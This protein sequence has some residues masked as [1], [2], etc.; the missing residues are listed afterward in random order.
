MFDKFSKD[1]IKVIMQAQEE[2]RML[3]Q[4]EV[5]CKHL[6][7][8]VFASEV[9]CLPVESANSRDGT[10]EKVR[11]SFSQRVKKGAKPSPKELPFDDDAKRALVSAYQISGH[12][13]ICASHIF[14]ALFDFP[15]I[16]NVFRDTKID[17]NELRYAL[18]YQTQFHGGLQVVDGSSVSQQEAMELCRDIS[19]V[20]S[21]AV[22]ER[23]NFKQKHL[24][25]ELLLL[26]LIHAGGMPA[27]ILE[28]AGVTLD[29]AREHFVKLIGEAAEPAVV[30][31]KLQ[32]TPRAKK[33]LHNAKEETFQLGQDKLK[34]LHLLLGFTHEQDGVAWQVLRENGVDLAALRASV[35]ALFEETR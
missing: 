13:T 22:V 20:I 21:F 27:K 25:S 16:L 10:L 9:D 17:A 28:N 33:L 26:G 7:L 23:Q 29:S 30:E 15:A 3:K 5:G 32:F 6:L 8:G 19:D 4:Q 31:V 1:A 34:G 12:K 24:S 35:L 14:L 18:V 11:A 2:A